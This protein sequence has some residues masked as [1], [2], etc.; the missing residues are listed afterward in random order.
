M[1]TSTVVKSRKVEKKVD[2]HFLIPAEIDEKLD[3][4]SEGKAFGEK[5][6][7]VVQALR[8]YVRRYEAKYGPVKVRKED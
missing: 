7:H 8:T 6:H 4:M 1:E 5:T 2:R 3:A